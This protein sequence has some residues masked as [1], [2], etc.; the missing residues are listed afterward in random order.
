VNLRRATKTIREKRDR[1]AAETPDFE[2]L[3]TAAAAI[4]DDALRRLDELLEELEANVTAAGGHVHFARDA[5]EANRI[6]VGL[7][8]ETG[9]RKVVKVKSMTTVEI[10]LNEALAAAGVEATETDL[11][12][13]IVQLGEDLPS[14]IVVPAIH[15]NRSEIRSIFLEH[16]GEHGLAA[17]SGLSNE[18]AALASAARAHLRERFLHARVAISGANFAIAESGA[19]VVVESEGNGRMCL[20]LPET[21]I[22]VVGIEKV[23]PRFSDLEVFLQLL[24]RSA[25]GER[26]SPY[27][28]IW[29]GV[30][31][32]DGPSQFHLV[33]LDNGR[34]AALGD[35]V[36]RQALRCIRCAACLNVCPVYERVGGHAYGSVYPGPI[37]AVIAPQLTGVAT[38]QVA[39]ALPFASTLCG[40]CFE[41]CPVRIDI[42]R[43]LVHLRARSVEHKLEK[44]PSLEG[45]SMAAAG[46]VFSSPR[47]LAWAEQVGGRLAASLFPAGR[48][49]WLP[50]PLSRWTTA[51]DAPVPARESFREWWRTGHVRSGP[52]GAVAE[53]PAISAVQAGSVAGG[54]GAGLGL[55]HVVAALLPT[56]PKARRGRARHRGPRGMPPLPDVPSSGRAAVLEAVSGALCAA[57]M[58]HVPITRAYRGAGETDLAA[59][60]ELFV[61]RVVEYRA[62]VSWVAP[63]AVAAEITEVLARH[64]SRKVVVPP[65][66]PEG[67]MPSGQELVMQPDTGSLSTLELDQFDSAVTGCAVAIADTGTIVLDG[68]PTQG[69]RALSLVPDHLVVVVLAGQVV[70]GLPDAI[71]RLSP[72]AAQTWISGP[73]ATVDIE[74]SRVEGVHGPRRL[75]M[76]LVGG[77]SDSGWP[78]S[79]ERRTPDLHISGE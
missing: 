33:L 22:S 36:G 79:V 67:W 78:P 47:R 2:Q 50:G 24:A 55:G 57:P 13:L 23:I 39:A 75:N 52:D 7:V 5:A 34:S 74:L 1:L 40:A 18:P 16:M 60:L 76:I 56:S 72:R 10:R 35:R 31:P 11:A 63:G 41:V 64:G 46:M 6:V 62:E 37:G 71:A 25:T 28:S 26:M 58:E 17:P 42:P 77:D 69:R 15:R 20:T 54:H 19:L 70:A 45:L 49:R 73:S 44:G 4:K 8:R 12:E 3:R 66:L 21:L 32:G 59:P 30:T 38:E 68:G 61:Q 29:S 51:R 48:V 27:T 53:E 65:D 14:H 43:L 9:A